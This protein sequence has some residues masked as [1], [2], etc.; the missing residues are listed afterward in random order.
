MKSK[1]CSEFI[2]V[3]HEYRRHVRETFE[4]ELREVRADSDPCFT[5]NSGGPA[6]NVEELQAYI[7]SLKASELVVFTHSPP[8]YQALNPVEC[9]LRQLYHLMNF[10]L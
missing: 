7:D 4:I 1:L 10:F 6:R 3:L 5:D 2:R 8:E 9:A